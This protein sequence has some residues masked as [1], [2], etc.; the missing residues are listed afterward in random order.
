VADGSQITKLIVRETPITVHGRSATVM[1]I[2]NE[3]T[4]STGIWAWKSGKFNVEVVNQLARPTAVHWHGLVLPNSM[5]GVPFVTQDPIPAGGVYRYEFPLKQDG[6]YWM[7][8]HY[9][10]TEQKLLSA[11]L[12][13]LDRGKPETGGRNLVI[14]LSDFSFKSPMEILNE[15]KAGS[16]MPR[17]AKASSMKSME[18]HEVALDPAGAADEMKNSMPMNMDMGGDGKKEPSVVTEKAAAGFLGEQVVRGPVG[19]HDVEYDALLANR[20]T[21]DDP[22]VIPVRPGEE[23]RLRVIAASSATNFLV[24]TGELPAALLAVDGQEIVPLPGT[25]FELAVA[26]RM[27][28][29]VKIPEGKE[30]AY[31]ILAQG[32]GVILRCGVILATPGAVIPKI[33]DTAPEPVGALGVSQELLLKAAQPLPARPVNRE[34]PVALGGNMSNYTWTI[35]GAAYPDAPPMMVKSGERVQMTFTNSTGMGHPMHLHGHTFQVVE[36]DGKP[37]SGARRDTVFVPAATTVKIQFDADNP[38]VWAFHCHII[39]HLVTGMFT[40]VKYEEWDAKF[41]K[42]DMMATELKN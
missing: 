30:G 17:A 4:N 42:P 22:E 33:A 37:I 21:L 11:P 27:D 35:N 18:P 7:H 3:A 32:E 2:A 31:P 14:M 8:S 26:Q 40:V 29:S 24:T 28:L 20:R 10:L 12:I 1:E 13:L 19:P 38:G 34:I 9:G 39:Y 6:T 41:W 15:L 23:L 36:I 16:P 5:D 25:A